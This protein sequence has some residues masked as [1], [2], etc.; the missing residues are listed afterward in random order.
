[1][2]IETFK[3]VVK[4]M[5]KNK[6]K[7]PIV[8]VGSQGIGKTESVK[9]VARELDIPYSVLRLGSMQDTGDMLGMMQVV[10]YND[11]TEMSVYAPPS[12]FKTIHEKGSGIL[13]IDEINRCK[14]QLQD[15][16]MQ[17]L[18]QG[19]FNDFVLPENAIIVGAMNP[20]TDEF[21]VNEFDAA[22]IDRIVAVPVFNTM[23]DVLS[24]AIQNN[25]DSDIVDFIAYAGNDLLLSGSTKLP[26]KKFTAR[27]LRQLNDFM[28][29]VREVPEAA[30]DIILGCVGPDGFEKWKF[31]DIYKKVPTAAQYFEK[32]DNYNIS[33]FTLP[34][35]M[36]LVSRVARYVTEK[37]KLSE[38]EKQ[39]FT[40][41]CTK[42]SEPVFAIFLRLASSSAKICQAVNWTSN[43]DLIAKSSKILN[44]INESKKR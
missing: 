17:L 2:K 19:R 29:V 40:E 7:T 13:F 35:Q 38:S 42:L 31:R 20:N 6:V 3:Q 16:V 15:A 9:Q 34:E 36:I 10:K 30:N 28:P 4:S 39:T 1:M 14:P 27:S 26:P 43:K 11:G 37:D 5:V 33:K 22:F 32:P 18:D 8:A 44:L 21:D 12:W 25:W 41:F 23:E 24:F